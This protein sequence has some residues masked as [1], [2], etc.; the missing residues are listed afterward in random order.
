[1]TFK[2]S[3]YLDYHEH[4]QNGIQRFGIEK[5]VE[6]QWF[7]VKKPLLGDKMG[8]D[9]RLDIHLQSRISYRLQ[10]LYKQQDVPLKKFLE[11][12]Q[13]AVKAATMRP[14]GLILEKSEE[15]NLKFLIKLMNYQKKRD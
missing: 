12:H 7:H 15:E 14:Q 6:S 11:S 5:C 3:H 1:M 10:Q 9:N 8:S 13:L 2:S 4:V